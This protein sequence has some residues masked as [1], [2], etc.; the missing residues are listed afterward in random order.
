LKTI[1]K[2]WIAKLRWIPIKM[3]FQ[4]KGFGGAWQI[5][6]HLTQEERLLLYHLGRKQPQGV[7]FV[8]IGSY[9]GASS[10]FLAAAALERGGLLHCVDTWFN[11]GMSEG[12]QDTWA[13][14]SKNTMPFSATIRAHRAL[15]TEVAAY[16]NDKIDLLFV[17]GDH[18][19]EACKA[20]LEA[21]LPHLKDGGVLVMHDYGWAEGVRS[22]VDEIVKPRQKEKGHVMQNT[23]WTAIEKWRY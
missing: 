17:D 12:K 6:T 16:F 23:Y 3:T 19:Y 13:E 4:E 11:E 14:F 10:C 20:D 15:S 9:L 2:N 22:V 18:T 7:T 5:F 1:A 21:W 8:E